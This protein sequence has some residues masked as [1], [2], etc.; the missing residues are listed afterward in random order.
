MQLKVWY[1]NIPHKVKKYTVFTIKI[2]FWHWL[3]GHWCRLGFESS[4]G[5]C[6]NDVWRAEAHSSHELSLG[7][8]NSF[9]DLFCSSVSGKLWCENAGFFSWVELSACLL[10]W[11]P[12]S[13]RPCT[14]NTTWHLSSCLVDFANSWCSACQ[15]HWR[16]S[17][18]CFSR[19]WQPSV[20]PF[21]VFVRLSEYR[22][23]GG[24]KTELLYSRP[25]AP[26][27]C[28]LLLLPPRGRNVS[29]VSWIQGSC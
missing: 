21:L 23:P 7:R 29:F 17:C 5:F 28:K 13:C 3:V 22:D 8:M 10:W 6:F 26:I 20:V 11:Q 25:G 15:I 19:I 4:Q 1:I 27:L 12:K 24:S 2:S 16:Y 18:V 14:S 9:F